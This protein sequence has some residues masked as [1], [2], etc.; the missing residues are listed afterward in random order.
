V[1]R[2]ESCCVLFR[3][4]LAFEMTGCCAFFVLGCFVACPFVSEFSLRCRRWGRFFMHALFLF[5]SASCW[6]GCSRLDWPCV[7]WFFIFT[8]LLMQGGVHAV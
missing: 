3:C 7:L 1:V 4:V 5:W 2:V 8:P 6:P